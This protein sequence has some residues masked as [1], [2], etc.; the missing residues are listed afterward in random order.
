LFRSLSALKRT[1]V[2]VSVKR[3]G[4]EAR[5]RKIPAHAKTGNRNQGSHRFTPGIVALWVG[6]RPQVRLEL[7]LSVDA[8][9]LVRTY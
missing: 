5:V 8:D 2:S 7:E 3:L 9:P 4:V 1:A 6:I